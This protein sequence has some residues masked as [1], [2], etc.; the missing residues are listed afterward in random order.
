M[1]KPKNQPAGQTINFPWLIAIL[2]LVALSINQSRKRPALAPE[3]VPEFVGPP[4]APEI[5]GGF[6]LRPRV[7]ETEIGNGF[8]ARIGDR[9][10]P[11]F[12]TALH[13]FGPAG[14]LALV[15]DKNA[16]AEA[17][18]NLGLRPA[19]VTKAIADLH[20]DAL[21]ISSSATLERA[22]DNIDIAAFHLAGSGLTSISA[23]RLDPRQP[24]SGEAVWLVLPDAENGAPIVIEASVFASEPST[25]LVYFRLPPKSVTVEEAN[26][27]TGAP[28]IDIFGSVV[29]IHIGAA[30]DPGSDSPYGLAQSTARFLP[31]LIH[32][33]TGPHPGA[34]ASTGTAEPE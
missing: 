16:L 1:S 33:S 10:S 17:G 20:I 31:H 13:R 15:P 2:A 22:P 7:G 8:A 26:A 12:L 11:V 9:Q 27:H 32:A 28:I 21:P 25:G 19:G 3:T 29:G 30:R 5:P 23:A 34:M 4:G 14:G 24:L 6:L 18:A